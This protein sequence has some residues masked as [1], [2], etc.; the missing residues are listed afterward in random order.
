MRFGLDHVGKIRMPFSLRPPAIVV[1]LY[2]R[3]TSSLWFVPALAVLAGMALAVIVFAIAPLVPS[4]A[5]KL[6]P[7]VEAAAVKDVLR[8]LASSTLTVATVTF[9][10]LMIVL[11]MT[12][13]TFSPRALAG[14]MRDRVNQ[15][16]LGIFLGGFAFG[17]TASLLTRV[18]D[19]DQ[20]VLGLLV[21]VAVAAALLVLATLVYFIHHTAT[22]V[23]ITNLVLRLHM[24]A[25]RALDRFLAALPEERRNAPLP[26]AYATAPPATV[27][28]RAVG[29]V[30]VLA[31][32]DLRDLAIRHDVVVRT[33]RCAGDFAVRR[34][35]LCE[36]WPAGRLSSE[37]A[38][39]IRGAYALGEQRTSESDPLLGMELLAEVAVR[40]LSPGT[41]DPNTAVNC[42]R[43]LGDL[44][45]RLA[46]HPLPDRTLQD[47]D[48]MIRVIVPTPEFREFVERPLLPISRSGSGPFSVV[49]AVLSLLGDMAH[50]TTDEARRGLLEETGRSVADRALQVLAFER[51]REEVRAA[52][53]TL[54]AVNS[55]SVSL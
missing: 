20:R 19:Y 27:E 28:S 18:S 30:Q 29:Y 3:V 9:S 46:D 23:Q 53:Q 12:A 10:I 41:N 24:S 31:I 15:A 32:Q 8:L 51:E 14:Y 35:P 47:D 48:D 36:V 17:L 25:D 11:T 49:L 4:S 13:S 42:V 22:A 39:A 34:M 43:Y 37:L 45:V 52:A 21:F 50:V 2:R 55:D 40:A 33:V 54:R 7:E 6:F 1:E 16:T 26:A 5:L 38:D 44:M